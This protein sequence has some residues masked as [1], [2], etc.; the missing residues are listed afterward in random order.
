MSKTKFDDLVQ[1]YIFAE[2]NNSISIKTFLELL[3]ILQEYVRQSL[4]PRQVS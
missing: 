1:F 3:F 4:S 2:S